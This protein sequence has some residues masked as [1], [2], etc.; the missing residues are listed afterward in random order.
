M[1]AELTSFKST[2]A[3]DYDCGAEGYAE[4]LDAL[5]GLVV[6][7]LVD[8]LSGVPGP[9]LDA[10]SGTGNLG[11]LLTDAV[12]LDISEGQLRYNVVSRRVRA[13]VERLPF[14]SDSFAAVGCAFGINHCPDPALAVAEMARVAPLVALL[15]WK[16]PGPTYVPKDV[17]AQVIE[18][19]T[20]R[21]QTP[22]RLEV[23]RLSEQVGSVEAITDLLTGAGLVADV[24]IVEVPVPWPGATRF[25]RFRLA[26]AAAQLMGSDEA[27]VAREAERAVRRLPE[28]VLTFRPRVVL[29]LGRRTGH[30]GRQGAAPR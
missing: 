12:A 9:V 11:R 28:E 29:G 7:P 17:V 15:T 26:L 30:V 5:F 23:E 8:V 27:A 3:E 25:V 20:Q 6:V 10:C 1:V 24:R 14:A 21:R 16:R 22:T 2:V 4:T 19:H 18:R 13:D